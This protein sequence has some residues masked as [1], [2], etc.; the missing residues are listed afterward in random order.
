MVAA[1]PEYLRPDTIEEAISLLLK[2][3]E[4]AKAIAGG[5][6]LLIKLKKGAVVPEYIINL[7]GIPNLETITHDETE[8]LRIGALATI[9]SLEISPLIRNKFNALAKA[10]SE[11]GTLQVRN[12]ATIGGNLCNAAPSAE[13]APA[14]LVLE[15]RLKIAGADGERVVPIEDFFTGPGQTILC[16]HE[17]LTEIQIPNPLPQ[18]SSVYIA[19]TLRRALDLANVGVAVVTTID[20]ETLKDVKIALG[21]V[22][23]TPIRARGAEVTLRGKKLDA[24]LLREASLAAVEEASPIDDIRSSAKYRRRMIRLLVEKAII[25]SLQQTE[26]ASLHKEA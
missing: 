10:A 7:K 3:K 15:A 26:T 25:Q 20:G 1:R 21:S 4:K 2:Y 8:G 23:P 11:L 13:T 17:I 24:A 19:S 18:S 22:A 16:C 5:T 14:L 12:H 6:D 9:R